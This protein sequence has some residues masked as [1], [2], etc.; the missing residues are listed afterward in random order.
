MVATWFFRMCSH[1][2]DAAVLKNCNSIIEYLL[3]SLF[4][5]MVWEME[6]GVNT[7]VQCKKSPEHL[8]NSPEQLKEVTPAIQRSSKSNSRISYEQFPEVYFPQNYCIVLNELQHVEFRGWAAWKSNLFSKYTDLL[9]VFMPAS[10]VL[11]VGRWAIQ[12]IRALVA[13]LLQLKHSK[14][15]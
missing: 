13:Q 7:K 1:A 2:C 8:E 12:L 11:D 14:V 6:T 5:A 4:A 10:L 3:Q 15:R 9:D